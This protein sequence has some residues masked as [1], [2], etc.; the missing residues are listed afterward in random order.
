MWVTARQDE[1]NY[2]LLRKNTDFY[3]HKTDFLNIFINVDYA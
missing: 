3:A 1:V 2:C